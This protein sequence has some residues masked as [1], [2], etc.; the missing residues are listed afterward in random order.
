MPS[1]LAAAAAALPFL[2]PILILA[3]IVT[4]AAAIRAVGGRH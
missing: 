2:W 3:A 1:I 4:L